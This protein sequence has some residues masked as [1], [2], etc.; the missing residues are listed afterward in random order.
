VS[1]VDSAY[2]GKVPRYGEAGVCMALALV[3]WMAACGDIPIRPWHSP[4]RLGCRS[5][6]GHDDC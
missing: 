1:W 2:V 6:N 5:L 4:I 3:R